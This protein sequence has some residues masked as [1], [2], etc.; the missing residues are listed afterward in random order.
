MEILAR[1]SIYIF[2]ETTVDL[3]E[4]SSEEFLYR[5]ILKFTSKSHSQEVPLITLVKDAIFLYPK[6]DEKGIIE[7]IPAGLDESGNE[8]R[9]N[10]F[11]LNDDQLNFTP[12][13]A[14]VIYGYAAI[15]PGKALAIAAGSRVYF[16]TDSGILVSEDAT[17]NINGSPSENPDKLE[18]E[19][20]F[21]G[22]KLNAEFQDIP[23]QWGAI[24][25]KPGSI[26]NSVSHATIKNAGIGI[27]AEGNSS[28]APANL[29]IINTQ[30]YN[31]AI[32]GLKGIAANILAENLVIN[33]S[34]QAS[35]HITGGNYEFR[36][37]TFANYWGQGYRLFPAVLIE[38]E[39]TTASNSRPIGLQKANFSYCIIYGNERQELHFNYNEQAAFNFTFSNWLLRFEDEAGNYTGQALYDFNDED[40][41]REIILNKDPSFWNP[42]DNDLRLQ[43]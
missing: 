3:K 37:G 38:N 31:S 14:Y 19:V 12:E 35:L 9:I 34:G 25:F 23:G 18:K 8:I 30:I 7:T 2:I 40:H 10:G 21:Q 29:H 26:N 32:N 42:R 36:H 41:Y 20:V 1:D 11:Y 39:L 15:P 17:L 33:N 22:D 6:K 16:H 13:K 27:L 4:N 5:D 24:W 28:E 43:A